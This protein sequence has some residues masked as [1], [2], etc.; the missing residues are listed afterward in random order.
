MTYDTKKYYAFKFHKILFGMISKC[1]FYICILY[2]LLRGLIYGLMIVGGRGPPDDYINN[3]VKKFQGDL[4]ND[5]IRTGMKLMIGGPIA[6]CGPAQKNIRDSM[7]PMIRGGCRLVVVVMIDDPY[8]DIKLVADTL[9][10]PSQCCKFK[11]IEKAPRGYAL[12]LMLKINT[13]LGGCNH[14]LVSRLPKNAPLPAL[15]SFQ[16]PPASL[17][18]LF[19]EP[20]MLVGIDVS[21]G[22]TSS[23]KESVAAVVASMDGHAWQYAAHISVQNANQEVVSSLQDAMES[24]LTTFKGRND[25]R[26]PTKIVVYRDGLG[27]G[28]FEQALEVELPAIKGAIELM[29]YK[30]G[31][32]KLAIVLCQKGHHTRIA[33]EE[34][35]PNSAPSILNVCPGLCVDASGGTD[36]IASARYNE[37]YLNS[38]VAIQGT[39]KPCKYVILFD[40]IG[41]KTRE[42]EL[43]TYWLTYMYCRANKSVSLVA[44]AYYAHWAAKRGKSLTAAGGSNHNLLDISR[45]WGSIERPGTM[46]FI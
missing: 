43:M 42:I 8:N 10:L 26:L 11:K 4:E 36:S 2:S 46:F 38:H 19:D 32:V 9:G 25:G 29:G 35:Q 28:Q 16:D 30:D 34:P 39:C 27:E 40:E 13:K 5:A 17:S 31:G 33:Y 3:T 45:T 1:L 7:E 6:A 14:T 12:N 20:C 21:H 37:F 23:T 18:W 15:S 44:P 24:L 22:E 41:F